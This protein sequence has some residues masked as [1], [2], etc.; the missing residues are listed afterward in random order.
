MTVVNKRYPSPF[1]VKQHGL[2]LGFSTFNFFFFPKRL[3][4]GHKNLILERRLAET[5]PWL[6]CKHL[7]IA[8]LKQILHSSCEVAG[9]GH[10]CKHFH[11]GFSHSHLFHH[12]LAH[13][14]TMVSFKTHRGQWE[15]S[16]HI[17]GL[18]QNRTHCPIFI[19]LPFC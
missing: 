1:L 16:H 14:V 7:L 6:N 9:L 15:F 5:L 10:Q 4:F 12:T 13:T 18:Y 8:S 17:A 2:H 11:R 19:P 3:E